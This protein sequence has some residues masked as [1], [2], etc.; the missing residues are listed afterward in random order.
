MASVNAK[1]NT[2][3]IAFKGDG[4]IVER[5]V[6]LTADAKV[7]IDD[8]PGKLADVPVNSTAAFVLARGEGGGRSC[9]GN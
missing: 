5:I 6:Q 2:I 4:G 1:E 3:T 8:K 9:A 7:F